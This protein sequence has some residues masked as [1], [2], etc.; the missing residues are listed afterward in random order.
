MED[1]KHRDPPS[2]EDDDNIFIQPEEILYSQEFLTLPLPQGDLPDSVE[3]AIWETMRHAFLDDND[4]PRSDLEAQETEELLRQLVRKTYRHAETFQSYSSIQERWAWLRSKKSGVAG[5]LDAIQIKVQKEEEEEGR[6]RAT[7]HTK[8]SR[9][10]IRMSEAGKLLR[11]TLPMMDGDPS[12]LDAGTHAI[13]TLSQGLKDIRKL[14]EKRSTL[15]IDSSQWSWRKKTHEAHTGEIATGVQ[16]V[17]HS[18]ADGS[19]STKPPQTDHTSQLLAN[20]DSSFKSLLKA[21]N[22]V[23]APPATGTSMILTKRDLIDATAYREISKFLVGLA[24]EHDTKLKSAI[25]DGRLPTIP[26]IEFTTGWR[27]SFL[28]YRSSVSEAHDVAMSM[29]D[30]R[31]SDV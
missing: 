17:K 2:D 31:N 30:E 18:D 22:M 12:Y 21:F 9:V 3:S 27:A 7:D 4:P 28:R 23:G 13:E 16:N 20:F 26:H 24:D 8:F 29:I 14:F 25:A 19:G 6:S 15:S 11:D 1:S 5:K 10:F